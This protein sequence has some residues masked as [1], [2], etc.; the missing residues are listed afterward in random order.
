MFRE[1]FFKNFPKP[2]TNVADYPQ[3]AEVAKIL[4]EA[5]A[6]VNRKDGGNATLLIRAIEENNV[7]LVKVL[8]DAKADPEIRHGLKLGAK[9]FP[10]ALHIDALKGNSE[11]IRL[12]VVAGAN[13]NAELKEYLI[14]EEQMKK[15]GVVKFEWDKTISLLKILHTQYTLAK[16]FGGEDAV[17]TFEELDIKN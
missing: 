14:A 3:P 7:A 10:T 17:K 16:T 9:Q 12:L 1:T 15:Y 11:I 4:I 8:L 13:T 6:D 2:S 5:G